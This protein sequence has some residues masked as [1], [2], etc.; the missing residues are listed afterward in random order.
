MDCSRFIGGDIYKGNMEERDH[1]RKILG[2]GKSKVIPL[3]ARCGPEGGKSRPYRD[4]IPDRPARSQSYRLSYPAHF[5]RR[6]ENDI[7]TDVIEII[8]NGVDWI[9]LVRGRRGGLLRPR[10]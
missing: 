2:V 5:R 9:N 7:T 1:L 3:Q 10:L 4:S 8:W 6:W